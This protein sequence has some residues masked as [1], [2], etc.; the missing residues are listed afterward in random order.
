MAA[1]YETWKKWNQERVSSLDQ[2]DRLQYHEVDKIRSC[3]QST[4]QSE[5]NILLLFLLLLLL[6]L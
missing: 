2:P 3:L 4:A 1:A 6:I 5:V